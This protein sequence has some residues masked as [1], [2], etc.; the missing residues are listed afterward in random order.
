MKAVV[1]TI[2]RYPPFFI[3]RQLD[4]THDLPPCIPGIINNEPNNSNGWI[5]ILKIIMSPSAEE[6]PDHTGQIALKYML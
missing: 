1:N 3:D 5:N 6:A 2:S 4:L